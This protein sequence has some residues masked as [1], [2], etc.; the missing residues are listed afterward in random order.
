VTDL[1]RGIDF[2]RFTREAVTGLLVAY[3]A[4]RQQGAAE[5][6]LPHLMFGAAQQPFGFLLLKRAG[7]DPLRLV[8]SL[9]GSE[10]PSKHARIPG[11]NRT[12]A[13][14][15]RANKQAVAWS[16]PRVTS[17]HLVLG[18]VATHSRWGHRYGASI[19]VDAKRLTPVAERFSLME[20]DLELSDLFVQLLELEWIDD[21]ARAW[22]ER[23]HIKFL[24]QNVE[25][26]RAS[27]ALLKSSANGN[28]LSRYP[29]LA[30]FL[31]GLT[32]DTSLTIE[33]YESAQSVT[34]E[35]ADS[36]RMSGALALAERGRFEEA[37]GL[38]GTLIER[39][40]RA[41][42]YVNAAQIEYLARR[43]DDAR[44]YLVKASSAIGQESEFM[45]QQA[46][47]L[48]HSI[49]G[50]FEDALRAIVESQ[51]KDPKARLTHGSARIALARDA[52]LAGDSNAS[53]ELYEVVNAYEE[54]GMEGVVLSALAVL[55]E[56]QKA[57]GDERFG[58]TK[59]RAVEVATRLGRLVRLHLLDSL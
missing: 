9:K 21:G 32:G 1:L 6:D 36:L 57:S 27:V 50:G 5:V 13:A 55:A 31:G 37:R 19:G 35:F 7:A 10:S 17:G 59:Q 28:G 52:C 29:D 30:V 47:I 24:I 43:V 40:P 18:T 2:S 58:E 54:I 20:A 26:L 8:E 38:V 56:S 34:P 41:G 15:R 49:D 3:E 23:E 4:A 53:D 42:F 22:L 45:R 46:E 14:M 48:W 11:S 51:P 12:W 33:S 16:H 25:D 39:E 44:T